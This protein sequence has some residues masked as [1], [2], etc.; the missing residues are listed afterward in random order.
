MGQ[1]GRL[2]PRIRVGTA[3]WS[4]PA[5]CAE[6]FLGPGTHLERYAR[7]LDAAEIDSIFYRPHRPATL[8]RWAESVPAGFRFAVKLPREVTHVRRLR[9]AEGPLEAYLGLV[10]ELGDRLGPLLIQLPPSLE[11]G[12]EP[13]RFLERFRARWA[14]AAAVEPRHAT[15][16]APAVDAL[17]R[18]LRI[19][20]VA[21][22][23]P[24]HPRDGAPGGYPG[25]AYFRL[26]GSPR[27]YHSAYPPEALVAWAERVRA[28]A[29]AADAAWCIFDN[30]AAGAALPDAL[31]FRELVS[32]P[33]DA[34]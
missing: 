8:R 5:A 22:D 21:A 24:R 1:T 11:F 3:G 32:R 23:P 31:R 29:A 4:V 20:R 10:A 28:A 25:L 19:A 30:T 6:R 34:G 27:M 2:Q 17:L 14:G 26:H 12:P 13:A 15:W 18:E 7:V 16:F 9:D 33:E